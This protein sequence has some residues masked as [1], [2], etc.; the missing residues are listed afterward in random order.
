MDLLT[1]ANNPDLAHVE[2]P[3]QPKPRSQSDRGSVMQQ[4]PLGRETRPRAG[5]SL[6]LNADDSG[7]DINF[8]QLAAMSYVGSCTGS[9]ALLHLYT[10]RRHISLRGARYGK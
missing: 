10:P 1:P 5:Y 4:K 9:S 3:I 6:R 7:D 2:C 8:D